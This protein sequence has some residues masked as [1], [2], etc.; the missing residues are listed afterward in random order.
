MMWTS[1]VVVVVGEHGLCMKK[2]SGAI[3]GIP[4]LKALS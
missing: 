3:S 2:V 4:S 1:V